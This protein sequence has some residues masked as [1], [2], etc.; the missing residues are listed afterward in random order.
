MRIATFASFVTAHSSDG[1]S[2]HALRLVIVH[3]DSQSLPR[4]TKFQTFKTSRDVRLQ[5][6]S[7]SCL[8]PPLHDIA[9]LHGSSIKTTCQD[10]FRKRSAPSHPILRQASIYA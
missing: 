9:S 3:R 6:N 4:L 7:G 8:P 2:V 1:L 5:T 10:V